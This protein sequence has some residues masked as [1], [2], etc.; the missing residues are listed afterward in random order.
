MSCTC[1]ETIEALASGRLWRAVDGLAVVDSWDQ[2]VLE[3]RL[4]HDL[5]GRGRFDTR[6]RSK[7]TEG[8]SFVNLLVDLREGR[9]GGTVRPSSR[10]PPWPLPRYA[11]LHSPR[12]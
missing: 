12:L 8:P 7:I 9:T 10:S 4:A 2:L 11:S 6:G 3:S 5:V 1:R